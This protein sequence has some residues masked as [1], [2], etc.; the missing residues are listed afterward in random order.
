MLFCVSSPHHERISMGDSGGLW[1][2]FAL[3]PPEN[4]PHSFYQV[5]EQNRSAE[6][7]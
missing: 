1:S 5:P 6:W 2:I 7:V 4:V 3:L